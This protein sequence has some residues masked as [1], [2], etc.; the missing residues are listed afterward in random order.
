MKLDFTYDV[1]VVGGGHAGCEAA[2][3][4]SRMGM[5]TLL[6]NLYLDNT[7][8]MPCNPSIGGAAKGHLVRELD[9]LGGE[10]AKATDAATVHLRWLNTSK[11]YAVQALRAQCDLKIY[12][13]HY[14][15][16]ILGTQ[17]LDVY[18]AR[19]NEILIENGHVYGVATETGEIFTAKR[20]ILATGTYLASRVHQGMYCFSS[21][22]I[23]QQSSPTSFSESL[24]KKGVELGRLRTDTPPRVHRDTIDW[25]S[26]KLQGSDENPE[27]F[28]LFGEKKIHKGFYCGLTRTNE[29]TH[30]IARDNFDRSPLATGRIQA[31]GPRYC[32]S[33]DDKIIKFP[34][35][36][37]HPIFLEP[38][39][40]ASKEVYLQN[41]STSLPIDVQVAMVQSLPG[42]ERAR[43]V[44]PGYAIEYDFIPPT[45]LEPWLE[46][47]SVKGLFTAGQI[48][49]TSGYEEAAAQG[50]LAGIN[51][52]LSLMGEEPLVL[53][54]DQAY[55]GVLVDDLVTR[56]TQ[57]PYRMLTS[58]CEHRLLLRHD[59]A[60]KRL[61]E[62]G[63][64]LGL[65]S[66][67]QWQV[68]QSRWKRMNAEVE[69]LEMIRIS[70]SDRV[71]SQLAEFG[72]SPIEETLSAFELLLRP[73]IS[74]MRL[75]RFIDSPLEEELG[76]RISI[77]TKYSGYISRQERQVERLRKM[78]RVRLFDGFPFG[79]VQ[80]LSS[81]ARQKFKEIQPR[82]LG[83]ASRIPGVTPSDIQLLQVA[84]ER[85]RRE[86]THRED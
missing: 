74:W 3:A 75:M 14:L 70:P 57:E 24:Q 19:V 35:R 31:L 33:I 27:C 4:S 44:R 11:G 30:Q 5:K 73:E 82:S 50:L 32:P 17:L 66:P 8:L 41:F 61:S 72:S 81:E 45:Q 79:K 56:G 83:Q 48:N 29:R 7:A 53:G 16:A 10:Q 49:G 78:D 67:M 60:D 68:I 37:S 34:D 51:A 86:S 42:C 58:R 15:E 46:L 25:G 1:L 55:L 6:L 52:A 28:S 38:M 36:E 84:L 76:E 21:G 12:S 18:Q 80:G 54:R 47:K 65:V 77:E 26:L 63:F 71:N 69:R 9:A 39:G 13:N 43:L 62:I 40:N 20:L 22:P 2:L 59:N 64:K 85:F 23:G